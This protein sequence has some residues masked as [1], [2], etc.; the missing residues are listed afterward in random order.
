MKF[1]INTGK[2]QEMVA[3][4]IKGAGNN[5][6]IPLTGLMGIEL[7]SGVL[8][9]TTTDATNYLYIHESGVV[10]DDFS[11][12][13][14][15]D[16]FAKLVS[17]MTSENVTLD[18][19]AELA[20]LEIRGNGEY[21]IE[22]PLDENGQLIKYPAPYLNLEYETVGNPIHLSTIKV[23]LA[24]LKSSL[25]ATLEIPCYTGYY[26]GDQVIATDTYKIASMDVR[27]F[28]DNRLMSPEAFNLL[29]L[30]TDEKIDVANNKD[31]H[32]CKFTSSTCDVYSVDM[33]GLEEYAVDAIMGLIN[34]D[35]DSMCTIA[36]NDILSVLDRILLFVGPYD[37]N[38]IT[39]TFTSGGLQIASKA[40]SG[41]ELIP[42]IDSDNFTDFICTVDIQMLTSLIKSQITD[43][44][45]MQYGLDNA[46]KMVDGNI[47]YMLSLLDD[48]Q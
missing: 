35:Y 39:L 37:K 21:R 41:T 20:V 1:T 16:L 44:I 19:K 38:A 5:K 48:E 8:T 28:D 33:E 7:K 10:G 40:S 6:L 36:K 15:A 22:L 4:S 34:T 3:K 31:R 45:E 25:A 13:V 26:M 29:S 9:F 47:T 11:V 18:M 23:I 43:K 2:L 32:I 46:I 12:T 14:P 42:Y 30:M 17:K 24:S 27:L